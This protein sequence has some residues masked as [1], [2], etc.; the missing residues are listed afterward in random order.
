MWRIKRALLAQEKVGM[1]R[2]YFNGLCPNC[3][4][5]VIG[6]WDWEIGDICIMAYCD[7]CDY[8]IL[9]SEWSDE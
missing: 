9:E 7:K 4:E 1:S 8:D 3:G 2:Q 6:S 5:K